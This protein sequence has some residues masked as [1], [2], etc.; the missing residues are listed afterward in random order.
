M[1][2]TV[3]QQGS[4]KPLIKALLIVIVPAAVLIVGYNVI[5]GLFKSDP[6]PAED[7]PGTPY[8]IKVRSCSGSSEIFEAEFEIRNNTARERDFVVAVEWTAANGARVATDTAYVRNLPAYDTAIEKV[9]TFGADVDA[10][11]CAVKVD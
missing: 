8:T 5:S 6:A 9:S 10:A 4:N 11:R 2:P 7:R 3:P 1:T